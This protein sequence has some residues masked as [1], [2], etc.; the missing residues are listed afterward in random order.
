MTYTNCISFRT[1]QSQYRNQYLPPR[2]PGLLSGSAKVKVPRFSC[3][4]EANNGRKR[5]KEDMMASKR[6]GGPLFVGWCV[7]RTADVPF[8]LHES[9]R[10]D[11]GG[12]KQGGFSMRCPRI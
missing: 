5:E 8:R 10:R 6:V 12:I 2:A 1:N 7:L 9:K 4:W 3:E 11:I